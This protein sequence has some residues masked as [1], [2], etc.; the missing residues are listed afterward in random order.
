MDMYK[1][2][3]VSSSNSKIDQKTILVVEDD[4]SIGFLLVEALR[5]ET[6]YMAMLVS[7]GIQALKIAH[8]IKPS[9]FITD[10]WLPYINGLELYDRLQ[11]TKDLAD[12]PTIIMSAYLPEQEVKKR[13]LVGLN[14]PF[15]LD[16]FL[17]IVTKLLA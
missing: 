15:E 2:E 12:T 17:E 10:Y 5:Q 6:P 3:N 11:A 13:N 9:L 14:K 4:A 1:V 7:D 8:S 16:E